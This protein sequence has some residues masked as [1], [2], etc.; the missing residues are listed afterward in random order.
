VSELESISKLSASSHF[1]L[2]I[3]Q[4]EVENDWQ[5]IELNTQ[6]KQILLKTWDRIKSRKSVFGQLFYKH[7]FS[8]APNA[9]SLFKNP[10]GMSDKF[11][12]IIAVMMN[13][14]KEG[15][16][17][18]AKK[19]IWKLGAKHAHYG[20]ME[21]DLVIECQANDTIEHFVLV[22]Q[23]LYRTLAADEIFGKGFE[24]ETQKYG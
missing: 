17:K 11:S 6:Q 5:L 3:R 1:T 19:A 16:F 15:K 7:L 22:Q 2:P 20:V 12:S 4:K 8:I 21:G 23:A 10:E 24:G 18:E 13:L 9:K 14:T